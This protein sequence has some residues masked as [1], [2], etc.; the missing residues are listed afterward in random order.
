M[1]P[2]TIKSPVICSLPVMVKLPLISN[3]PFNAFSL[4]IPTFD[5]ETN[6]AF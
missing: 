3:V 5:C 1:L 6:S 2:P 4:P